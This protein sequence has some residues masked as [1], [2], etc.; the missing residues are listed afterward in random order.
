VQG[1]IVAFALTF[2]FVLMFPIVAVLVFVFPIVL[3]VVVLARRLR[4]GTASKDQIEVRVKA[5]NASRVLWQ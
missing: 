4:H 1:R 5:V 3:V 2:P